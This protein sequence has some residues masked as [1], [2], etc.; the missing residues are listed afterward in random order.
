MPR[1]STTPSKK[2]ALVL[3]KPKLRN[4]GALDQTETLILEEQL[5]TQLNSN[6]LNFVR[7]YMECHNGQKA[8]K[9]AGYKS[10]PH[11]EFRR[12]MSKT[13]IDYYLRVCNH[14]NHLEYKF[15]HHMITREAS[16]MAFVDAN[17]FVTI[18]KRGKITLN[19]EGIKAN[20]KAIKKIVTGGKNGTIIEFHDKLGALDMIAKHTGY[21]KA[22]NDQKATKQVH[23]W[24]PENGRTI[25]IPHEE[26]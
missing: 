7:A 18:S 4:L 6:E 5:R 15:Q 20:G 14:L 17:D 19:A 3:L 1:P 24:I 9:M 21:F 13:E 16:E 2:E 10:D 8:V 25:D 26:N 12:L 22:D 23:I 11:H